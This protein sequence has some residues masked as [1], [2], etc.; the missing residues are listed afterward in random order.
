M[1]HGATRVQV[2]SFVSVYYVSSNI[3]TDQPH[4][5]AGTTTIDVNSRPPGHNLSTADVVILWV[6]SLVGKSCHC[7]F[8][9]EA[10]HRPSIGCESCPTQPSSLRLFSARCSVHGSGGSI[11]A[12][13]FAS[14]ASDDLLHRDTFDG[15]PTLPSLTTR[16]RDGDAAACS[17]EAILR[18]ECNHFESSQTT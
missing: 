11:T 2:A 3:K 1:Q 9:T 12:F 5:S 15:K 10:P 8:W 16:E 7:H 4:S 17:Q 14:Q 18:F 6:Q 13:Q